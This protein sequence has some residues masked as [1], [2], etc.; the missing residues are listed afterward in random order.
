[1]KKIY[2]IFFLF[3]IIPLLLGGQCECT[4]CPLFIPSNDSRTSIINISGATNN[5][6]GTNGQS[7]CRVCLDFNTDA[8]KE[9]RM[10]LTAPDGST[11]NL[12]DQSGINVNADMVFNICFVSCGFTASPDPTHAAVFDTDDNWPA[13][14]MFNGSYYPFQGCLE[15]LT[16][17]VN[18]NWTLTAEDDTFF[19]ETTIV[20]WYLI[21]EDDDGIGCANSASCIETCEPDAGMISLNNAEVCPT[22]IIN[23]SVSNYNQDPP[24]AEYI[25][26]VDSDGNIVDIAQSDN[27]DFTSNQCGTFTA[28]S[29]N[30]KGAA[31]IPSIG[32]L[33]SSYDCVTNCCELE[34]TVFSIVDNEAPTFTMVP[35]NP[36]FPGGVQT[37]IFCIDDIRP[38]PMA[39]Y[40]DNCISNGT[41]LPTENDQTDPCDGGTVI[42]RWEIKDSCN[43]PTIIEQTITIEAIP[44]AIFIDPPGDLT[45]AC[46]EVPTMESPL[47]Y[48]NGLIGTCGING[49]EFSTIEN[50]YDPC[51]GEVVIN[52]VTTDPCGRFIEHTQILTVEEAPEP[53]YN[54][55]PEDLTISCDE[56]PGTGETLVLSNN[57]MGDCEITEIVTPTLIDNT[58]GCS[59]EII[60][61]WDFTDLCGRNYFHQQTF[62]ILELPEIS[63]NL[64][65]VYICQGESFD[66]SS[67]MV[68]DINSTGATLSY[69]DDTPPGAN[70]ELA[71]PVVMPFLSRDYYFML[72]TLDGADFAQFTI[73]VEEPQEIANNGDGVVCN[74][75]T[76]YN[77][78]DF[79]TDVST[80]AGNWIDIDNSGID[81]SNPRVVTFDNLLPST[82]RFSYQL[83]FTNSCPPDTAIATITV[84]EALAFNITSVTCAPDFNSYSVEFSTNGDATIMNSEGTLN[85]L[86]GGQYT[87]SEITTGENLTLSGIDINSCRDTIII[88][89]PDCNCPM[90]NPPLNDGDQTICDTELPITLSVTLESNQ[91]AAWYSQ[92]SGGELL[93][94]ATV[95]FTPSDIDPNTYIYYVESIDLDNPSCVSLVRTPVQFTIQSSP[96]IEEASLNACRE[97]G[98]ISFN[99]NEANS[100]ISNDVTLSFTY[101]TSLEN[102]QNSTDPLDNIYQITNGINQTLFARVNNNSNCFSITP[103]VLN[104]E[105]LPMVNL[106]IIGSDTINCNQPFVQINTEGSSVGNQ[107]SYQWFDEEGSLLEFMNERSISVNSEGW[108]YIEILNNNTL[109]MNRDSVLIYRSTDFPNIMLRN[110]VTGE[111]GEETIMVEAQVSNLSNSEILW[112][113]NSGVIL[114]D[115]SNLNIEVQGPGTYYIQ[116]ENTTSNCVAM[117]SILINTVNNP[118]I[119]SMEITDDDCSAELNGSIQFEPQ[120]D[121]NLPFTYILN[122]VPYTENLIANIEAGNY[123]IEIIDA[124]GCTLDTVANLEAPGNFELSLMSTLNFSLSSENVLNA[125]VNL[126]P[127]QISSIEWTPAD[128]LSCNDCLQ[129]ILSSPEISQYTITVL[130][131]NGC[132]QT[133]S[134]Q[135]LFDPSLDIFVPNVFS[136]NGDNI[137]DY[138]QIYLSPNLSLSNLEMQI[139]DRWGNQVYNQDQLHVSTAVDFWDG[140]YKNKD[141]NSG[142]F[143]YTLKAT[144]ANGID[145]I[146]RSGD[147]TLIR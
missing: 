118:R 31:P 127:D 7:L 79:L 53:S 102:A 57:A 134:I 58:N 90:V 14:A 114:S 49:T 131:A 2:P 21:F 71:Q 73:I 67:V 34:S 128:N 6:L 65:T 48:S 123:D 145:E 126:T 3:S 13:D 24:Y 84:V 99:L 101:F 19:D 33:I 98:V 125:N 37:D 111:C 100:Q 107:F 86:G 75:N 1:M 70:N 41:L 106:N 140:T 94:S 50:S 87:I 112:T 147:I 92:P 59:G 78:F 95:T 136:P 97:E 109:C 54:D 82:Y 81:L 103:I 130:D 15:D 144:L 124:N 121:N 113:T 25:L 61:E 28:Y 45:I 129:P 117:D 23:I 119:V 80:S 62:T 139:Y 138:L 36:N 72:S 52:W 38:A 76:A 77:L 88:N 93:D 63:L 74:D 20:N 122:G 64:D 51:G 30:R 5:T 47:D 55:L 32:D 26:I 66:L 9:L 46:D 42:R 35:D 120:D 135:I 43:G 146:V 104:L 22:E 141:L 91:T 40:S 110:E 27:Y 143:I 89:A 116:V 4:N 12:M 69:H 132:E 10:D 44:E 85:N 8:I 105:E 56:I 39:S 60:F 133:K 142:V 83:N 29:Y 17:S 137:N 68:T 16:G 96:I 115:P 18:G 11:V 108:Y